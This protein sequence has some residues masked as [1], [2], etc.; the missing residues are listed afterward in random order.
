MNKTLNRAEIQGPITIPASKSQTIRALLVAL[1]AREKSVLRNPLISSDTQSCIDFCKKLGAQIKMVEGVLEIDSTAFNPDKEEELEIDCKNSGTTLFFTTALACTTKKTITFT[2]D[3]SL[4]QRS[5]LPLLNSLR[6]LGASVKTAENGC[7]PY[8]VSGQM[9]G[10]TTAIECKTSQYLSALLLA[11]PLLEHDT[12]INVPLLYEEPYIKIT[13]QWLDSQK[14]RYKTNENYSCFTIYGNQKY[15]GF[16]S[17]I[18][19]DFSSAGYFFCAAA[20]TGGSVTVSGLDPFDPQ[21]DK[22]LLSILRKMGCRIQWNEDSVKVSG[23]A[24]GLE[25]GT[26]DLN[27]MPDALPALSVCCCFAKGGASLVR[28]PQ[29]RFKETDRIAV[30]ANNLKKLGAKV[31]ELEDG[32]VFEPVE[33]FKGAQVDSCHDHRIAMAMAVASLVA[34]DGV[35]IRDSAAVDVTFPSFFSLFDS[36]RKPM[37]T[38]KII[39]TKNTRS[40]AIS[41][42]DKQ[43]EIFDVREVLDDITVLGDFTNLGL[44]FE[45]TEKEVPQEFVTLISRFN[46]FDLSGLEY[47]FTVVKAEK[48][49]RALRIVEMLCARENCGVSYSSFTPSEESSE[50]LRIRK[51]LDD[52]EIVLPAFIPFMGTYMHLHYKKKKK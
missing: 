36:V 17:V 11:C 32:L 30:M 5:A 28:V 45:R 18:H 29:A 22:G 31:R 2:G 44:V 13:L 41:L 26:F 47:L 35:T 19:G 9:K 6:D 1:F 10:G 48:P 4:K 24:D 15:H 39:C 43:A 8:T 34:D 7:A 33:R 40:I 21:G 20:V 37:N 16:E 42:A 23:P 51:E 25:G 52:R 49:G 3:E 46:E 50:T 38:T 12:V 27:S 14:I